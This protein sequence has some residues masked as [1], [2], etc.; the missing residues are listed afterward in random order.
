[1]ALRTAS[2]AALT[3]AS[4]LALP[5]PAQG[6]LPQV[7]VKATPLVEQAP[8]TGLGGFAWTQNA[9]H[10]PRAANLFVETGS[11]PA[12][13]VNPPNTVAW[14][15]SIDGTTLIYQQAPTGSNQSDIHL[16]DIN[17]HTASTPAGINTRNWEFNATMSGAW[18]EFGRYAIQTHRIRV[19]LHNTGTGQNI[20]LA[21]VTRRSGFAHPGQVNGNWAV[22]D[23]CGRVCNVFRYDIAN[24]T[25]TRIP[26]TMRGRFQ[27]FPAVAADGT[28]FFAHSGRGC[29]A[30]T[31]L[32]RQ[33]IGGSAEVLVSFRQ[34]VELWSRTQAV[35]DAT[36]GTDLYY[37]RYR[38]SRSDVD[39]YKVV[40]P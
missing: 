4:L 9:A 10:H 5:G 14:P 18:I 35:A 23:V 3:A 2:V 6:A 20:T 22:W 13:R 39:I 15:G 27:Y 38:C 21:D 32:V 29:G 26:N 40:T 1:M 31:R 36:S 16:W 28:A 7:P 8:G 17:A 25:T 12:I 11:G 33:P 34:G 19:I 24:G 37:D 30:N